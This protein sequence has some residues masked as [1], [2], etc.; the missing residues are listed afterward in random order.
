LARGVETELWQRFKTAVDAVFGAREAAFV[1]RDAQF[2]A[3]AAER[4]ALI[5]RLDA[6]D[7]DAPAAVLKRSL[8]EAEQAWQRAGPVARQEAAAL[9]SRWR[10]AHDRVRAQLAGSAQRQWHVTCDSLRAKLA[11]CVALEAAADASAADSARTELR[12]RWPTLAPLP[13][14]WEHALARRAG[15]ADADADAAADASSD[16]P[17][18]AP[19]HRVARPGPST[20]ELLLQLEVAIGIESPAAFQAARHALKLLALKSALEAR[21]SASAATTDASAAL[22]RLL[23]QTGLEA[24][25]HQR[26]AASI[27]A[28][29]RGPPV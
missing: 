27:D 15:L 18:R 14:V 21:P 3:G 12:G 5:E 4:L 20:D 13:A 22:A 7:A 24:P 9:D 16:A 11:L 1:A 19:A 17:V 29:R 8:A 23:E 28:L 2:L 25:Q 26:L 10:L 6:L